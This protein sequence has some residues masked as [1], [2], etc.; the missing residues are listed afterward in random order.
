MEQDYLICIY[1][2]YLLHWV[3]KL[4]QQKLMSKIKVNSVIGKEL[5]VIIQIASNVC[6]SFY[7][8]EEGSQFSDITHEW[9]DQ[10]VEHLIDLIVKV[11]DNPSDY[12]KYFNQTLIFELESKGF[13]VIKHFVSLIKEIDEDVLTN[14]LDLSFK[15]D[16]DSYQMFSILFKLL[17]E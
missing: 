14:L 3:D 12:A 11:S 6:R 8:S 2:F 1:L 7:L 9:F 17:K 15:E 5:D 13:S 16:L 10:K 4:I